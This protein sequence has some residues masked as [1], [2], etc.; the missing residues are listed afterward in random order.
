MKQQHSKMQQRTYSAEKDQGGGEKICSLRSRWDTPGPEGQEI[1]EKRTAKIGTTKGEEKQT[2]SRKRQ[3]KEIPRGVRRTE[4]R[5][6]PRGKNIDRSK[7]QQNFWQGNP[8]TGRPSRRPRP[9]YN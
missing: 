8:P 2:A 3:G 5:G 1:E 9:L 6:R 4:D 7:P